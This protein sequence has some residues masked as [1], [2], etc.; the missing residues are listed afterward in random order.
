M[1]EKKTLWRFVPVAYVIF[2]MLPIYWLLHS[3][4]AWRALVHLLV[5]PDLWE[6]TPHGLVADVPERPD[7]RSVSTTPAPSAAQA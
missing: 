7:H 1:T 4:A 2:L 5:K 3:F 6:K